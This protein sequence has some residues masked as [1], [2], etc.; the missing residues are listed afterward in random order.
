MQS[1]TGVRICKGN[2][3]ADTK[4]AEEGGGGSASGARAEIPLQPVEKTMVK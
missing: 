3:S 4:V 2:N 1:R